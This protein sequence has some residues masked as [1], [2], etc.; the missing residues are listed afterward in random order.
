MTVQMV[1]C[2]AQSVLG[3]RILN[4]GLRPPLSPYMHTCGVYSWGTIKDKDYTTAPSNEDKLKERETESRTKEIKNEFT[5]TS[6][7]ST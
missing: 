1:L 7:S 2:L 5:P 6:R 4:K 3:D